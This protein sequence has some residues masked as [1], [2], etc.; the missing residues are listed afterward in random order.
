MNDEMSIPHSIIAEKEVV[1]AIFSEPS[2]LAEVPF[3]K[4][5]H[6]HLPGP[7]TI[8]QVLQNFVA[9]GKPVDERCM[10]E[11]LLEK[12]WLQRIGGPVEV[13]R[14]LEG[15]TNPAKFLFHVETLNDR[16]AR[17]MALQAAEGIREAAYQSEG[18]QE[19]L[20]ATSAPITAIQDTILAAKPADSARVVLARVIQEITDKAAGKRDSMGI[21][22]GIPIIDRK[23]MGLHPNRTTIISGYPSGG[24]SV[25]GGQFCAEAFLHD[26]QTLFVSL[27]MSK[28]DLYKRLLAYIARLKGKAITDPMEYAAEEEYG[29]KTL[30]DGEL[31]AIK[32][33]TAKLVSAP[34]EIERLSGANESIIAA[35]IRKHHRKNPLSVVCVD[36]AQRIRPSSETRSQNREQQLSHASK[37]LADLA[38]ELGFH[39]LLLS[40]LNK[41]GAAKG[42]EAL[43]EDCDLHLSIVQKPDTK[44][45]LGIS[46]V[47]DRHHGQMGNLLKVKLNRDFVRFDEE[48]LFS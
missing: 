27:E 33:A 39:L 40:Q 42:A 7:K 36:Y 41:E 15:S 29:R 18:I 20:E 6:F 28:D 3:L 38:G 34:F 44:E 12:D 22:T 26:R 24:K 8:F 46:V 45:H 21:K 19:L 43:N 47:K 2:L 30:N 35:V 10:L 48:S 5:E 16:L 1:A 9:A 37:V 17:R 11:Y 23:F 13:A 32:R 25:L 31:N 14:L 4:D